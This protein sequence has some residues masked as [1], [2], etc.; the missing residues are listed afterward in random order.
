MYKEEN[1]KMAV[2]DTSFFT[3]SPSFSGLFW[4]EPMIHIFEGM[5]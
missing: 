1:E 5:V 4:K 2:N 3:T